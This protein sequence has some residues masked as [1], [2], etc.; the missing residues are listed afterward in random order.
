MCIDSCGGGAKTGRVVRLVRGT[1]WVWLRRHHRWL[2]SRR[3][4]RVGRAGRDR[5]VLGRPSEPVEPAAESF[6][7]GGRLGDSGPSAASMLRYATV[8]PTQQ[9]IEQLDPA[10]LV[11]R[12]VAGVLRSLRGDPADRSGRVSRQLGMLSADVR[13]DVLGRLAVRLPSPDYQRVLA[14]AG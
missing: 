13:S 12:I 8:T 14:C 7:E 1:G 11:D 4:G 9:R 5:V 6:A 10:T 3:V 2:R